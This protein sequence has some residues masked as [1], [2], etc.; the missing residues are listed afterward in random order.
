M[1][2]GRAWVVVNTALPNRVAGAALARG[3]IEP[4]RDYETIRPEVSDGAGSRFDFLLERQGERCWVEVKSVTLREGSEA[5]FPD[6]VTA[7]G[8]KHLDALA[9]RKAAGDRAVMLYLVGRADVRTF[10]PAWDIDPAYAEG[11]QRAVDRGVEI[12]VVQTK[13][14]R[15]GVRAG[16][17]LPYHLGHA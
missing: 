16:P 15:D 9:D 10:R 6:A 7:R 8:L 17:S 11:L 12:A 3:G 5:R 1:R 2:S 13:V 14:G 4:L